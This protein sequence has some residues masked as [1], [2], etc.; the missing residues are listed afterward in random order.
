MSQTV[1]FEYSPN[2]TY[3]IDLSKICLC[4]LKVFPTELVQDV[5]LTSDNKILIQVHPEINGYVN[6]W[7]D[8]MFDRK[9]N[10]SIVIRMK[11][12]SGPPTVKYIIAEPDGYSIPVFIPSQKWT[13][14]ELKGYSS[15][16]VVVYQGDYIGLKYSK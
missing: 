4:D 9:V 2:N 11:P 12:E 6:F 13:P 15:N 8:W 10:G 7:D 14:S 16:N 5:S 1:V 3:T